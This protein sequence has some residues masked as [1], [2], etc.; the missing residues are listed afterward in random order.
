MAEGQG[1]LPKF[2]PVFYLADLITGYFA[3]AGMMAA[4]LRR[5]IE[6]GSYQVK[7]SLTRSAMWVQELGLLDV[8][9][10]GEV[11]ETDAYPATTVSINTAYG[12][13]TSLAPPLTFTNLTLPA[14]DRL[15]PYGADPASWP[16]ETS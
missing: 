4:L 8:A 1:G 16:S 15:V 5:A 13:V 11:P 3:A 7:L 9:A 2:S 6:G 14:T 12:A 10:Q